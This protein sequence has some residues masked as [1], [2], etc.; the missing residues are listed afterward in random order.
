MIFNNTIRFFGSHCASAVLTLLCS[1]AFCLSVSHAQVATPAWQFSQGDQYQVETTK[2][3]KRT[4]TLDSRITTIESEVVML[5]DWTITA[6]DDA[7]T[8]TVEQELKRFSIDIGDPAVP[9]QAIEYASD[10]VPN[11][12][13]AAMRKLQRKSK[14]LI[15][16]KCIIQMASNGKVGSVELDPD[17]QKKL[18]KLENSPNLKALFSEESLKQ[19]SDDFSLNA[20][21]ADADPAGWSKNQTQQGGFGEVSIDHK[22]SIGPVETIKGRKLIAIDV[23]SSLTPSTDAEGSQTKKPAAK[24]EI[25]QS[26]TSMTGNGSITFDVDGNY[27]SASQFKTKMKSERKYREKVIKTSLENETRIKTEKK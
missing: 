5:F 19:M 10:S 3:S 2:L 1:T 25:T 17:S 11:D 7:G 8:A 16:L 15:G 22:F 20:I 13:P 27:F 26:L 6:V 21:P 14:P 9:L 24:N 4:S 12:L 18:D 23:A